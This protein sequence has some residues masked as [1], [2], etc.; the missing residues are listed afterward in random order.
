M[1]RF[2]NI[3]FIF[4]LSL[5]FSNLGM[6]VTANALD[7]TNERI[8]DNS[9][10]SFNSDIVKTNEEGK[11][12]LYLSNIQNLE[13]ILLGTYTLPKDLRD[14]EY[15]VVYSIYE[16]KEG[17]PRSK[18][19]SDF[20]YFNDNFEAY[21]KILDEKDLLKSGQEYMIK[22]NY[23][24]SIFNEEENKYYSYIYYIDPIC[25]TV[26]GS[27]SDS[28]SSIVDNSEDDKE[29]TD[30][31]RD[32]LRIYD[33]GYNAKIKVKNYEEFSVEFIQPKKV[34]PIRIDRLFIGNC[35][36]VY[37]INDDGSLSLV[38]T[39]YDDGQ[40]TAYIKEN[41]NYIIKDNKV[42]F[43]DVASYDWTKHYIEILASKG[44]MGGYANNEFKP[45]KNISR[46]EF[47]TIMIRLLDYLY[48][49]SEKAEIS[50]TDVEDNAWYLD[51]LKKAVYLGL[52]NDSNGEF[53]P[54]KELTR[55]EAAT[56][57]IRAYEIVGEVEAQDKKFKDHN[58]I[59]NWAV[60][61]VYKA[62]AL[63]LFSGNAD[64][65]FKPKQ[66]VTRSQTAV[67]IGRLMYKDAWYK[68]L[69]Y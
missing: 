34:I 10:F 65:T 61:G 37:K 2:K 3:C 55:E 26:L 23:S 59:S 13:D 7:V 22:S 1:K 30:K 28:N 49:D 43:S 25:F 48:I 51:A 45:N 64:N 5:I 4:I 8:I 42:E 69:D 54:N 29:D 32:E 67:I 15:R 57:A 60:D 52:I 6:V 31:P 68:T 20:E 12:I 19:Y 38:K 27:E 18:I 40:F 36:N 44:I 33:K 47:I 24:V 17:F 21:F 46:A 56:I 58:E 50:F 35:T 66:P 11:N 53:M 41:G 62:V 9:S 14:N 63:E 39:G 16:V